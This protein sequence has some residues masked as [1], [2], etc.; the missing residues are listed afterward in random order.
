LNIAENSHDEE[1]DAILGELSELETQFS[2]EIG[3]E[4]NSNSNSN[5]NSNSNNLSGLSFSTSFRKVR[6]TFSK[7]RHG[8]CTKISCSMCAV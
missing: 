2:R 5:A 7:N 1:L 4:S 3:E 8:I 6:K